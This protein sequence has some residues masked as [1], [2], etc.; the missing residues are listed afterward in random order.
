MCK[1]M[2]WWVIASFVFLTAVLLNIYVVWDKETSSNGKY[3]YLFDVLEESVLPQSWVYV[4]SEKRWGRLN[5][6]WVPGQ[7]TIRNVS[8]RIYHSTRRYFPE[9]FFDLYVRE[10]HI[11]WKSSLMLL[12]WIYQNFRQGFYYFGSPSRCWSLKINVNL[13]CRH[14]IYNHGVWHV[15]C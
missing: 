14:W 12:F 10:R 4:Q 5:R 6:P 7:Q 2:N 9:F 15:N 13:N 1:E 3:R 11:I 8:T